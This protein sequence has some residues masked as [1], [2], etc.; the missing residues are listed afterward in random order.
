MTSKKS[1]FLPVLA[2]FT[3][4]SLGALL[5]TSNDLYG[6]HSKVKT[7]SNGVEI[8]EKTPGEG[9]T[10]ISFRNTSNKNINALQVSVSGSL[11]MVEF[12]DADEPKRRLKPGGVYEEWFPTMA[13]H[14]ADI[15]VMAVVFDDQTGAGDERL[16]EEVLETRRGVKKQL[17]RF[18]L[19]LKQELASTNVDDTTLNKLDAQLDHPIQDDASDSAGVR[20]G[21]RKAQQQIRHDLE[22]L[23][24]RVKSEPNFNIRSGLN[25]L[26]NRHNNRVAEIQ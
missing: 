16:V 15:S 17:M 5:W 1:V 4:I 12:L 20:L 7:I 13:P 10:K 18:G 3:S 9:A 2:F 19:L 14:N 23:K 25:M 21:R 26:E 24:R 6:Q 22:A 8:V 11:F